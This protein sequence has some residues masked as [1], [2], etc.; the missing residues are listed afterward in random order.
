MTASAIYTGNSVHISE[1]TS[2]AASYFN[3]TKTNFYDF[4]LLLAVGN[5]PISESIFHHYIKLDQKAIN[6]SA[7]LSSGVLDFIVSQNYTFNS[8]ARHTRGLSLLGREQTL[9]TT[10]EYSIHFFQYLRTTVI[11]MYLTL[12]LIH[13]HLRFYLL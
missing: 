5:R 11:K 9:F 8:P 3:H 4:P 7:I 1:F 12:F 2:I 13:S 6:Y 10:A